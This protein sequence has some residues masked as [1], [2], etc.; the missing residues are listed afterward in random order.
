P[1]QP[2]RP[3]RR[4]PRRRRPA[5][6]PRS[7]FPASP[8][9]DPSSTSPPRSPAASRSRWSSSA[10]PA[11]E[12]TPTPQQLVRTITEVSEKASLLV[13]EEIELAKAEISARVAK[14]LRG[15]VVGIVAG[16]FVA[17]GALF[18]LHG[19]S[20]FAWQVTGT[21]SSFWLGF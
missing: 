4:R 8:S 12:P 10:L 6:A 9:T 19:A 18:L 13:R 3:L 7:R 17:I 20:W 1:V 11:D 2:A 15:A 16:F 21:E 14:L 5:P